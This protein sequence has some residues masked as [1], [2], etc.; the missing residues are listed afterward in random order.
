MK[1]IFLNEVL[2]LL[3]K[4]KWG[5]CGACILWRTDTLQTWVQVQSCVRLG[6]RQEK[7]FSSD[8]LQFWLHFD[9][10]V[11]KITAG[12]SL[13]TSNIQIASVS[14]SLLKYFHLHLILV[15]HKILGRN[16][17]FIIQLIC[18]FNFNIQYLNFTNKMYKISL[19]S[20]P[21][22]LLNQDLIHQT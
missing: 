16:L 19:V 2:H 22:T 4:N 18:I 21:F 15:Q 20:F 5:G 13:L 11:C 14:V 3:S 10:D 17:S 6:F 1:L 12:F 9:T 7:H 8:T